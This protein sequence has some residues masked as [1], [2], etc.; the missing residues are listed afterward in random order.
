[1]CCFQRREAE[2]EEARRVRT[3]IGFATPA[4]SMLF[5]MCVVVSEAGGGRGDCEKGM[6]ILQSNTECWLNAAVVCLH[7]R[8]LARRI[9]EYATNLGIM[10]CV[11]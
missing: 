7:F 1:M 5:L 11:G 2:E 3:K 10:L 9:C 4:G 6:Q 8:E